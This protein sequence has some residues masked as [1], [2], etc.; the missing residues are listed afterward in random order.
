MGCELHQAREA[1]AES[2]TRV[3]QL[4]AQ[5]DELWNKMEAH[6]RVI[7]SHDKDKNESRESL[8]K[9]N[10]E[11]DK[12]HEELNAAA[13][14]SHDVVAREQRAIAPAT[15]AVEALSVQM[16]TRVALDKMHAA[17]AEG[18]VEMLRG[19]FAPQPAGPAPGKHERS[20]S[21]EDAA[22]EPEG[23]RLRPCSAVGVSQDCAR[24]ARPAGEIVTSDA[25]H[26]NT[27]AT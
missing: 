20:A 1:A 17:L 13:Q 16:I 12:L 5:R 2:A 9:V 23:K 7:A 21:W 26:V 3:T 4:R 6:K 11:N 27:P 10:E 18:E 15:S 24:P 14:W 19:M 22:D 8:T 25:A